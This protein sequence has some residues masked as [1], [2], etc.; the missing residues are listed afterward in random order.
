MSDGDHL[1]DVS[2]DARLQKG[3][4]TAVVQVSRRV[5]AAD[6]QEAVR[7]VLCL[8]RELCPKFPEF[9]TKG[10]FTCERVRDPAFRW[11]PFVATA[12]TLYVLVVLV[13]LLCGAFLWS[14]HHPDLTQMEVL[15]TF[16]FQLSLSAALLTGIPVTLISLLLRHWWRA[17][18][19][20]RR[21]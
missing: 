3:A 6:E 18:R 15:Q 11:A 8:A 9:V 1:Y 12:G 14:W 4:R 21:A 19:E 5:K 7:M 16:P 2:V 10:H 13:S 17:I 20:A